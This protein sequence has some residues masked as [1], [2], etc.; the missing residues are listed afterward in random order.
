MAQGEPA[1]APARFRRTGRC[2]GL[3]QPN[4]P[5]AHSHRTRWLHAYHLQHWVG[6]PTRPTWSCCAA[7]TTGLVHEGAWHT[8]GHPDRTCDSSIPWAGARPPRP[9][10]LWPD[11]TGATRRLKSV[12]PHRATPGLLADA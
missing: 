4:K 9:P 1:D 7:T 10:P 8:E 5:A 6:P 11:V 3:A 12:E 2:V